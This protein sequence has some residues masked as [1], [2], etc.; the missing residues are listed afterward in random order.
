LL[1]TL[2]RFFFLKG[3][4][5]AAGL[6]PIV[7]LDIG[8]QESTGSLRSV[9]PWD[10]YLRDIAKYEPFLLLAVLFI[11]MRVV[12]HFLPMVLSHLRA[13]LG[14]RVQNLNLGI[15][16]GSNQ[17]VERALNVL[18]MK[19]LWSKLRLSNKATDLRKSAS[20]ARAWASSFASVALGESSSSR[21]S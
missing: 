4:F 16:R 17:L 19:R 1:A 7:H 10:R 11:V 14:V 18:D 20:N 13:F 6:D 8:Q 15:P 9:T 5:P 21:Q 12:A 2:Q 3:C